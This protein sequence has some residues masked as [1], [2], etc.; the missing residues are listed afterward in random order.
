M[1]EPDEL[2]PQLADAVVGLKPELVVELCRRALAE[3][4]PADRA[5][6]EGLAR[7]MKLVGEKYAAKEYYVP[8]VLLAA[9]AMYSGFDVLK[10]QMAN[11]KLLVSKG[12]VA[13]GV[14]QGDMHDIGKNIVRVMVQASGFETTDLGRNVPLRAFVEAAHNGAQVIGLSS[15]MTTT[16]VRMADIIKALDRAGL[17]PGVR[18]IVGGAPVTKGFADSIGADGW[19]PDAHSAVRLIEGLT[20]GTKGSGNKGTA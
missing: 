1:A 17:R 13:L 8:E 16:M 7:G 12:K 2:L 5:M 6:T 18:V 19:A 4:L 20:A 15:L 9:R 3:G 10:A 11:G 14:V